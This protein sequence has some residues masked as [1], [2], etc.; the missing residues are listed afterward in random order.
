MKAWLPTLLLLLTFPAPAVSETGSASKAA[1]NEAEAATQGTP[2][3]SSLDE[4]VVTV[5]KKSEI[6][7]DVPMSVTALDSEELKDQGIRNLNDLAVTV[8]GLQQGDLAITSRLTLRGV[9]SGDNN[10]FEQ[11]VG[12]YVDSTTTTAITRA[13]NAF[14]AWPRRCNRS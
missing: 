2:E 7:Q 14:A 4:I 11:A 6:L 3:P 10:A 12:T 5:R 9:N 8:P 13:I 1:A